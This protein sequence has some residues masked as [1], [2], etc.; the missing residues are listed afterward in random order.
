M[1]QFSLLPYFPALSTDLTV[2]RVHFFNF[3]AFKDT[4][5]DSVLLRSRIGEYCALYVDESLEPLLSPTVAVID[6][7]YSFVPLNDPLL[8][9]LQKYS[10]ALL[11]CSIG[12]E[13]EIAM[14][15]SEQFTLLTQNFTLTEDAIAYPTGSFY[16]VT[17]WRSLST[18]RLVRPAYVPNETILY[19]FEKKLMEGLANMIDLHD[20][21]D[22]RVFKALTWVRY[23]FLNAD[24][25]SYESRVVMMA[26]AFEIFFDLPRNGK[27]EEFAG[28]LESLLQVDKMG[29][30]MIRK[31][32]ARGVMKTSTMYGWWARDFYSLRSRIV[33]EGVV[34]KNDLVNAKGAQHLLLALKILKFC[35]YRLL[36]QRGVLVFKTLQGKCFGPFAGFYYERHHVER[37]LREVETLI[38]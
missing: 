30:S 7:D 37:K 6:S 28:R 35:L 9:D 4:Y 16:R 14:C 10:L 36:E 25:N 26:T 12:D 22:E 5:I 21:T 38:G 27:E 24:G 32:N 18:T 2:N 13:Q 34:S 15:V 17:N 31:P 23:A 11:T 20:P 33:H 1:N 3:A 19:R 8:T 29:H